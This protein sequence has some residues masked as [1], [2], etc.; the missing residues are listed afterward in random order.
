MEIQPSNCA[1]KNEETKGLQKSTP[2]N[3]IYSLG[4]IGFFVFLGTITPGIRRYLPTSVKIRNLRV[5]NNTHWKKRRTALLGL[6][7]NVFEPSMSKAI[8][9]SVTI[10]SSSSNRIDLSNSTTLNLSGIGEYMVPPSLV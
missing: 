2:R 9:L 7:T 3:F 10:S 6:V 4:Y 5:S 8:G 1:R